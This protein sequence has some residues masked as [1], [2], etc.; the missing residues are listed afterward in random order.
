[1]GSA[2]LLG[3]GF[4]DIQELLFHTAKRLHMGCVELQGCLFVDCQVLHF[5]VSK[6]TDICSTILQ[7]NR[8][9]NVY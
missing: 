8:F 4:T 6:L 2:V 9:A 3:D 5:Q 1:M 7:E